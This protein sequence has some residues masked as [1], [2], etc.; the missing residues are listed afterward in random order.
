MKIAKKIP[1]RNREA[2]RGLLESMVEKGAAESL[3]AAAANKRGDSFS[4]FLMKRGSLPDTL[5]P[6]PPIMSRSA[7][8]MLTYLTRKGPLPG[9]TLVVLRPCELRA[10]T[11]LRK[12]NQIHA[13]NLV[14]VS[15]DCPGVFPL[16][17]FFKGKAAVLIEQHEKALSD[18]TLAGARNV[19]AICAEF[20]G[21]GADIELGFLGVPE[22]ECWAVA[23][24]EAG[25]QCLGL[26]EG[27]DVGDL[28]SRDEA[29]QAAKERRAVERKQRLLAFQQE[30]GGP[31]NIAKVLE[32]CLNCHNCMR[33]CPICFCQECYFESSAFR[34]E[35]DRFLARAG[36]KK[37]LSMP[38]DTLL[39]HLGRMSH[40][41][42]S[43]VSCGACEDACPAD[44]PVSLFFS[45]VGRSTQGIFDYVPGR[46][47]S[48]P[49]PYLHYE[50]EEFQEMEAP[51]L[52]KRGQD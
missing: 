47:V 27:E 44:V 19:C 20:T 26:V 16:K 15:F 12:L 22:G 14:T 3:F 23:N 6:L 13:D 24:T 41:S 48:E 28:S 9:K 1:G 51:Y 29:V 40:M 45:L 17:D 34:A 5:E 30:V 43:C 49:V 4:Y 38:A 32:N 42:V 36:R 35:A 18:G 31:E 11:E 37:G 8:G 52:E 46:D 2:L 25:A 39:F 50:R 10:V 33:V 21:E 7:A